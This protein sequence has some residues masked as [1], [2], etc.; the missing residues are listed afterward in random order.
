MCP[1]GT[2]LQIYC[3]FASYGLTVNLL[4]VTYIEGGQGLTDTL[5]NEVVCDATGG[6]FIEN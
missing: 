3:Y 4:Y 5:L 6:V 1:C 2:I